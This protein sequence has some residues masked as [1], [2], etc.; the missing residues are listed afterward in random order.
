MW[1]LT[2]FY[3]PSC[4]TC[5]LAPLPWHQW[6]S[7][8]VCEGSNVGWGGQFQPLKYC[9]WTGRQYKLRSGFH[10]LSAL[11]SHDTF[12]V[13]EGDKR[14]ICSV[15]RMVNLHTFI[16]HSHLLF[17][18]YSWSWWECQFVIGQIEIWPDDGTKVS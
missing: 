2:W 18:V 14:N 15:I 13:N 17:S 12:S 4:L 8:C 5:W 16:Y 7:G 1:P 11:P 3:C 10:S 9:C 6:S